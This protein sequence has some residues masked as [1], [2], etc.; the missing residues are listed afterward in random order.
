MSS[1]KYATIGSICGTGPQDPNTLR[2]L[3]RDTTTSKNKTGS[4]GGRKEKEPVPVEDDF[5]EV[6]DSYMDSD[7]EYRQSN[8]STLSEM[9]TYQT[10]AASQWHKKKAT[11]SEESEVGQTDILKVWWLVVLF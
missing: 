2:L 5:A 9:S 7:Y 1:S 4:G 10:T 3:V 6:D 11:R 8:E